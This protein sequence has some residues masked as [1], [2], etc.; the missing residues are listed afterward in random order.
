MA[1]L[2]ISNYLGMLQEDSGSQTAINGIREIIASGD[3]ARI[4]EQPVRLLEMARQGF[5]KSGEVRTVADLI[6]LEI[7]LIGDFGE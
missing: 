6:D 7:E 1:P 2:T 3:T 5:E 4:G